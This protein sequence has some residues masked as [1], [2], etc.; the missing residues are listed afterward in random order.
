MFPRF[1]KHLVSFI[2]LAFFCL[3]AA[4]SD[5]SG[6]DGMASNAPKDPLTR[7]A[8]SAE[9]LVREHFEGGRRLP[10]LLALIVNG[11]QNY[12]YEKKVEARGIL[13]GDRKGVWNDRWM[14][15]HIAEVRIAFVNRIEGKRI[16]KC[17]HLR[18]LKDT[19]FEMWR[20]VEASNCETADR[21]DSEWKQRLSVTRD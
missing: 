19:E 16:E 5:D 17:I 4:G 8:E 10:L 6:K 12:E 14:P 15:A 1:S 18:W 20:E 2:G 3:L 21:D 11:G 13:G 7:T 9:Y